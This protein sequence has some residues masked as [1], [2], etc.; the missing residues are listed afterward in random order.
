MHNRFIKIRISFYKKH[1]FE[2]PCDFNLKLNYLIQTLKIPKLKEL[3]KSPLRLLG[4]Y[5][6][7]HTELLEQNDENVTQDVKL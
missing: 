5:I 4:L 3:K 2:V 6:S 1:L 7:F